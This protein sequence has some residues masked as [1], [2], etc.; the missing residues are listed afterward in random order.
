MPIAY[1]AQQYTTMIS[2]LLGFTAEPGIDSDN[3]L[4]GTRNIPGAHEAKGED[5][6]VLHF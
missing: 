6:P 5:L 4:E 3:I 2:I 1:K